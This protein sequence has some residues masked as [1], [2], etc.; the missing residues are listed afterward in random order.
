MLNRVF[1]G[2]DEP[3]LRP[4]VSWLLERKHDLVGM[5]VVVPTAQS[6]RR[7]REMLAE[8]GGSIL[9]PRVS[10]PG[11]LMQPDGQDIA[12]DWLEEVAWAEV[13]ESIDDW[14][15]YT[16][17][18]PEPPGD[19][20]GWASSLAS[21]MVT[22]RR[23]LQESSLMLHTAAW[24]LAESPEGER[25]Q[26]L[27]RLE[28][29][30]EARLA[31]WNCR[32]RSRVLA[33]GLRLPDVARIVLAGVPEMA[34]CLERTLAAWPGEV[35]ALIGAPETRAEDFSPIGRPLAEPWNAAT[36]PWP[37]GDEGSVTLTADPRQQAVEALD[38]VARGGRPS[39]DIALGSADQDTGGELLR[40]FT[41]AGW[42]AFHPAAAGVPTGLARWFRVWREWLAE[43]KLAVLADLLSL[44]ET[45]ILVGGKRAQKAK[46]LA[47]LRNEWMSTTVADLKRRIPEATFRKEHQQE[48]ANELL[49]AAAKLETLRHS[50]LGGDF[51]THLRRLL[52]SLSLTGET[53]AEQALSMISWL[54]EAAPLIS[55]LDRASTYWIDL[56]VAGLPA[57]TPV[58][59]PGRVID[60]QGWLELFHEPGP[61]LVL[62]GLNEGHVP[63]RG[64]GEPWLSEPIRKKLGLTTDAERGARDAY[65]FQA[66][67]EARRKDGRVDLFC[68]KSG[69]GGEALL[70]SRFLLAAEQDLLPARV[71]T[72]FRG[73]EPPEAGMQWHADWKWQ[74]RKLDPPTRLH[75]TSLRDYLKC[76]FRYYL[77]HVVRMQQPDPERAEWGARD[78]G[79]IAH[80]ILET[81]GRD[82]EAREY[83]KTEALEAY[84]SAQLDRII[85]EQFGRRSPLAIRIQTESLRNRLA[86]L[87]RKQA[88][89]RAAGWQVMDVERP[90]I[91]TIGGMPVSA[92]IDRID[93]HADG[94]L[95]VLDYKTGK[96]TTVEKEHRTKMTASSAPPSHL[97]PDGPA[98]YDGE[99]KGKSAR[100]LWSNLQ[101]PLY[102]AALLESDGV[103][104]IPGYFTIGSTEAD[105]ELHEWSD[106]TMDD[107]SAA[108]ACAEWIAG[109]ITQSVFWP[110]AEKVPYDDYQI[111]AAGKD[112]REMVSKEGGHS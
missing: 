8:A 82:P 25:W 44:P 16:A 98:F 42:I 91:L 47:V 101:L 20:T 43:P 50:L 3:F 51:P 77:K 76:P 9:A 41:R 5:L 71:R 75:V 49:E 100:F 13:L 61:H 26:A 15:P 94:R 52:T 111:L 97:D 65:L 87:A 109:Q 99:E 1:L 86:W 58:P 27:A 4:L 6:G 29:L 110:P 14:R 96:V 34:P 90:V 55:R 22:L 30:T 40:A 83:S 35:I 54:D 11:A 112:L 31:N 88:C 108:G 23:A 84:F 37:E 45:S 60:V 39:S 107:L 59:P 92:K 95:R 53:A 103:M 66:M 24:A 106:F 17:L 81:W 56:M 38:A 85:L 105:V 74:P 102:A 57:P 67:I 7:L 89:E 79:N 80:D 28:K 36:L 2:W 68:G 62:C 70:P 78:F 18:F 46:N 19:G 104:P 72:L 10:T 33:E 32:S 64:G 69:A 12:P 63:A 73:I 21:E 93:R 48:A